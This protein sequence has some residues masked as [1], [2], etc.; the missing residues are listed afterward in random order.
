M[1]VFPSGQ[2]EL[3]YDLECPE[4]SDIMP[5]PS[6]YDGQRSGEPLYRRPAVLYG[7]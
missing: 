2:K 3:D 1:T 4:L 7:S 6:I 5:T